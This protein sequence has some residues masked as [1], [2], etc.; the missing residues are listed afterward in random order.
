V[1][2]QGGGFCRRLFSF[3]KKSV[4]RYRKYN[5]RIC[6]MNRHYTGGNRMLKKYFVLVL[7]VGIGPTVYSLSETWVSFGFEYG[8]FF[9]KSYDVINTAKSYISSP[10]I[11]LN[12]YQFY[13][14]TN[15][16]LFIHDIFAFPKSGTIVLNGKKDKVDFS[17]YDFIMQVGIV[18]GPGFRYSF[19]N[20]LKLQFGI[21]FSALETTSFYS[22][23]NS[24][25]GT[26]DYSRISFNFGIG[27]DI[28]LKYDI[29]NTFFVNI[30][31]IL[32]YDFASFTSLDSSKESTAV[33]A[34]NYSMLHLRP[35]F[36]IGFNLIRDW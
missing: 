25:Y 18:I 11:N 36:T 15:T 35:Y 26:I 22:A 3:K 1:L 2:I 19:S 13:N 4:R 8:N 7:L 24:S 9:E 29:T 6:F 5:L 27:G 16:G 21:G 23:Y 17:A 10:A 32:G 28:G 12:V 14:G 20:K 33:W 30:G 34:S 31:S